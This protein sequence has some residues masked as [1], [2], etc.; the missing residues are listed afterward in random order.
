MIVLNNTK[1]VERSFFQRNNSQLK[2]KRKDKKLKETEK[3]RKKL[4]K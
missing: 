1:I 3:K 4:K 2:T